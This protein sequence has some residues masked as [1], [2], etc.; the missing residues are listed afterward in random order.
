[1][2][3]SYSITVCNEFIEIQK[4]IS[5]LLEYKREEDEIVILYDSKNGDT[6][7][8]TFLR[9]HSVNGEF[10]W[11]KGEFDGHFA[12]WKNKLNSYCT[13][14]TIVNLDADEIP[15]VFLLENLPFVLENSDVDLLYVPRVNTVSNIGLSHV[16]KWGWHISKFESMVEEKELDLNNPQD[17]DEYNLLKKYDLIIEETPLE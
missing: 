13:G 7:V 11:F 2:K 12:N 6:E 10:N 16:Q 9:S 1:M 15:N 14:D 3:I 4:L 17:L 8:E 5:L